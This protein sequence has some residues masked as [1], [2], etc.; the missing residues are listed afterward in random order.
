METEIN[1]PVWIHPV[2]P[3][4]YSR[5]NAGRNPVVQ[6]IKRRTTYEEICK[7]F[8]AKR[9]LIPP[10]DGN[11]LSS[12]GILCK[13]SQTKI[14]A[15]RKST[16]VWAAKKAINMGGRSQGFVEGKFTG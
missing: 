5:R 9:G 1:R 14:P 2:A 10:E 11:R 12:I 4:S 13:L 8:V 3:E 7:W 6:E 15:F 16:S